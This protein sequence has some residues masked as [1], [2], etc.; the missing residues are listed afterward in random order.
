VVCETRCAATEDRSFARNI[1]AFGKL[2]N[3]TSYIHKPPP[4]NAL[5]QLNHRVVQLLVTSP[6]NSIKESHLGIVL[7]KMF[8]SDL[9]CRW[10]DEEGGVASWNRIQAAFFF[11]MALAPVRWL[12]DFLLLRPVVE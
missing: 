3:L 1:V 9:R 8:S 11:C 7:T 2:K 10:E 4:F 6:N 12:V 5:K